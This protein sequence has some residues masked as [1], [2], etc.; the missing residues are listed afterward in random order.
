MNL[1]N[2]QGLLEAI[3]EI[4]GETSCFL[5][6]TDLEHALEKTGIFVVDS[7]ARSDGYVYRFGLRKSKW[8]FNCFA[9]EINT[10]H[11][12]EKIS[13]FIED[14]L[15]PVPHTKRQEQYSQIVTDINK[16]LMLYGYEI[17]ACGK[18]VQTVKAQS[19][20]K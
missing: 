19:L 3:A 10:N 7:G 13:R 11:S 8:L 6:K 1:K 15:N 14:V 20:N 2:D 16:V 4:I 5:S 9:Q 12:T 18:I 17:D